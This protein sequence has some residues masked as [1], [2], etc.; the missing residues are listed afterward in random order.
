MVFYLER[1]ARQADATL[2]EILALVD[3]AHH[4]VSENALVAVDCLAA[5][6]ANKVVIRAIALESSA[7]RVA[8]REIEHRGVE[9]VHTTQA[10]ITVIGHPYPFEV[11]LPL[12]VRKRQHVVYQRE[13]QRGDGCT[14]AVVHLAHHQIVA[15]Q[16]RF[17][18]RRR[19]DFVE[20]K[21]HTPNQ[22]CGN[23]RKNYGVSPFAG[24]GVFFLLLTRRVIILQLAQ[25]QIGHIDKREKHRQRLLPEV[26]AV[27]DLGGLDNQHKESENVD[28]RN[29]EID[30][31]FPVFAAHFYP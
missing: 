30:I 27:E 26:V 13:R 3:R 20:L 15:D 24:V 4:Y 11:R 29:Q 16:E 1:L 6:F 23:Q 2:D 21:A 12:A 7:N 19:G 25:S 22:H 5:I 9:A 17:L 8:V 28:G 31:P 10:R 18:H 14:R